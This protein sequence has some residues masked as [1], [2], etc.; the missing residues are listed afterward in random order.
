MQLVSCMRC[1][2]A[3]KPRA[4]YEKKWA[5][6]SSAHRREREK[7]EGACQLLPLLLTK[8]QEKCKFGESTCP[9]SAALV[10]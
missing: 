4:L 2:V 10:Q 3:P 1:K 5:L 8:Y 9:N 7:E 6:K